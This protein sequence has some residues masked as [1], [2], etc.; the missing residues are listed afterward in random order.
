M[1]D[2]DERPTEPQT[3]AHVQRRL[4]QK[5]NSA[6]AERN[7]AWWIAKA[8][9]QR[10]PKPGPPEVLRMKPWRETRRCLRISRARRGRSI[11]TSR[12]CGM[13]AKEF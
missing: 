8:L 10:A 7:E 1:E 3:E 5:P 12:L 2:D 4:H 9:D 11:V 6:A 13:Q